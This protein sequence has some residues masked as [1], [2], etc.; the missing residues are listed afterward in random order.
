MLEQLIHQG[1]IVPDLPEPLGLRISVRG[2]PID[3]T[4]EQEEMA[5][6]WAAKKDTP[7]A[8]DPV[9]VR[10]FMV[11][12]SRALGIEPVLGLDE[13]DFGQY[14]ARVDENRSLKEALSL[15]ERKALAAERKQMREE[16]KA[17][18]GYAIVNGQRVELGT[19][20]VEPSGIFMGRGQHPL[21]GRWKQG[22]RREDITLN[23]GPGKADLSDGWAEIVW[24]P[25][26]LWVARWKDRLTGKL[27]YIWLSDTAPVKQ[28]REAG[29]F[30]QA[31]KLDQKLGDVRT[32]IQAGL[33]SDDPRRRMIATACYLIDTLC[34]R[35][36]DE[37]DAE[38]A[39]TV[40]ATTLRPEHVTLHE[41]GSAEFEFLG[42]DS[43]HWHKT[44][45]LPVPVYDSLAEL[46]AHARPSRTA[47]GQNSNAAA[48]LP[49]IFPDVTSASVNAFFS[50][51]LPG[52]SAKKFRTY[53]ATK[54][55]E[56][57]LKAS[58]VKA[59]DPEYVKWR[60]ANLANLEA[61]QLCNHTKQVRGTWEDTQVRYDQ[62]IAAAQERI[63]AYSRQISD[64]RA[65]YAEL[66]HEAEEKESAADA[67]TR[68]A[69]QAR[70]KKRLTSARRR[71][72][73]SLNRRK[74]A[75]EALGKIKAQM[76]VARRKRE[77]NTSTSLKSYVDPRVYQRW[78]ERVEY[79]VLNSFYPTALR[80]KYAWVQ[81]V[82]HE[83]PDDDLEIR[84][85]LPAD[86]RA[87]A[88]LLKAVTGQQL[89][90]DQLRTQYLPELGQD[91]RVALVALGA[92]QQ[93]A[94]F[95]ALG[96]LYVSDNVPLIDCFAAVRSEYRT[97]EV[98]E[99][100]ADELNRHLERFVLDNPV[101][102]G[103]AGYS[104]APRDTAWYDQAPGLAERLGLVTAKEAETGAETPS[105]APGESRRG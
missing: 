47:D 75:Q 90:V 61:A 26:S 11:D 4:P 79:D 27:K 39:D 45:E 46:I 100:M 64:T 35:V 80:R 16:L 72:D 43:V 12:F 8:E 29:K 48:L 78:G 56:H 104:L 9:F 7:Y 15:A 36:G 57:S 86:L 66:Q 98:A 2:R 13:V 24:Q 32:A 91:W 70:Y 5:M 102:R 89:S 71:V 62:R 34:L 74:R 97:P 81:Y 21:R 3:L 92:E 6:A 101:K 54:V 10:N 88:M 50:R 84:P 68:E 14:Y 77:W 55:V 37:K 105:E 28:S 53:H 49:Q 82:D 99:R 95:A 42:K 22:A 83:E 87:V 38:E 20:M 51:I 23:Y 30:D 67:S 73:E 18:Y 60:A 33:A 96:P 41:D 44:L 85:C 94:A 59:S 65:R 31:L 93:V 25:E 69:V 17:R 76:E 19:Y 103:Q 58:R 52:L 40:G 63:N 1:V